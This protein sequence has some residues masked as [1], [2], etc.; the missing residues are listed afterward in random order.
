MGTVKRF[1]G[2]FLPPAFAFRREPAEAA[3]FRGT[4][5]GGFYH[6]L[7]RGYEQRD[8]LELRFGQFQ[9]DL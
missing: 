5:V 7:A 9:I 4:S 1:I 6:S 2:L 3:A 8:I